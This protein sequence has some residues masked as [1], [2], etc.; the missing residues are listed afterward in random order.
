MADFHISNLN[1]PTTILCLSLLYCKHKSA[2]G[3]EIRNDKLNLMDLALLPLTPILGNGKAPIQPI[4]VNDVAKRILAIAGTTYSLTHSLTQALTHSLYVVT[5]PSKRLKTVISSSTRLDIMQKNNNNC[6][7]YDC[8]GPNIQSFEDLL[9]K[10]ARNKNYK[11]RPVHIGYRGMER[12][13]NVKGIGTSFT[14]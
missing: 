2:V 6:V 10:F 9:Y 8:V 14:I 12:I 7:I 5:S 11:F 1:I 4:E 13:L 3:Q